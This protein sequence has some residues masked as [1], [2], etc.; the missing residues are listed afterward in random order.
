MVQSGLGGYISSFLIASP[1][2]KL[3]GK[4]D[5][6]FHDVLVWYECEKFP[7]HLFSHLFFSMKSSVIFNFS[8]TCLSTLIDS[9]LLCST[10]ET[11]RSHKKQ[12]L[13]LSFK[14]RTELNIAFWAT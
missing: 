6:L 12:C 11:I 8:G 1:P 5:T 4:Y 10:I 7:S 9:M 3:E 14:G 13:A 2:K